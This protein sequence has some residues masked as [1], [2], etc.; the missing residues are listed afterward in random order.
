M[1]R[2]IFSVVKK[3]HHSRGDG[4]EEGMT[5]NTACSRTGS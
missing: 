3:R 4:R 1:A 5:A 2:D